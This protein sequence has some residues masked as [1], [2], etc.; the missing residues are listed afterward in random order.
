MNYTLQSIV[1][2]LKKNNQIVYT[3]PNKLNIVGIRTGALTSVTFDDYIAFFYYDENGQLKGKICAATTD[4]SVTYLKNPIDGNVAT[5]ILKAGQYVDTYKIGSH[6]GKYTALIQSKPVTVIRDKDRNE[7]LDFFGET[8]T[9][10]FGINIHR[11]SYGKGNIEIIGADSAGCQVFKNIP[12]FDE[13]MVLA[14]ISS[15]KY[16]NN[17]TYTLIDEKE[18]EQKKYKNYTYA[19]VAVLLIGLGIT[20]FFYYK[21]YFKK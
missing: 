5:A 9:G 12:D 16:G 14:G 17:F 7:L 11:S 8:Q 19:G 10:L 15:N 6:R 20:T 3:Q 4:P 13:M 18:I 2:T 21:G 1:D